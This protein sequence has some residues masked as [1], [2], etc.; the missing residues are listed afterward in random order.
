MTDYLFARPSFLSGVGSI[1]DIA[2]SA[3]VYNSWPTP[4]EADAWALYSD[5]LAVGKDLWAAMGTVAA[6][7]EAGV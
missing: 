6:E 3:H 1:A 5:W 2:G 4:A 7:I